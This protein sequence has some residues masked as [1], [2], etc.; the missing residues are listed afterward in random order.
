MIIIKIGGGSAINLTGI[1]GDLQELLDR[2]EQKAIIVHGANA[3]RD[4]L[5]EKLNKPRRNITSLSGYTSVL[6]DPDT[7]DLQMMAYAG[8][9]NK[10]LVELL[11]QQNINAVGLSGIDGGVIRA[12]RNAGIRT[13]EKGKIKLLR[14]FSGKPLDINKSLLELLL[15][16]GYT[17]VLT[18]PILD[19]NNTA[20]N[21][22]ND[23]IVA[24][25]QQ[26]FGARQVVHLMEA[27]GMLADPSDPDSKLPHLSPAQ[28]E[29][30]E[31]AATGRYKRKLRAI[32]KL[33][34]NGNTEVFIG[35]G[36]TENP[37]RDTLDGKGTVIK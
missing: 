12:K 30:Q 26:T 32:K 3:L 33:F 19:Q 1:A 23:D 9:R 6:S 11:Q 31:T 20:V 5:A 28:L 24:L 17:P 15:N 4:S 27:P 21:S 18:V 13:R 16:N 8:L 34:T 14:D 35:D 36:R 22:E 10:R 29:E 37:L 7:I 2:Q 25:L